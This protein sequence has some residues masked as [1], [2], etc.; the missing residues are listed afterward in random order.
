MRD[1]REEVSYR[2]GGGR[3][4]DG[5]GKGGKGREGGGGGGGNC[6]KTGRGAAECMSTPSTGK[7][8]YGPKGKGKGD[9]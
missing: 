7:G 6:G 8:A 2:E 4:R 3:G 5:K 9:F 1:C